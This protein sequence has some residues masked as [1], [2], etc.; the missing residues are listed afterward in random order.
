MISSEIFTV[1]REYAVT[2]EISLYAVTRLNKREKPR[3]YVVPLLK[4]RWCH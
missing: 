3:K 4:R 2:K 1:T